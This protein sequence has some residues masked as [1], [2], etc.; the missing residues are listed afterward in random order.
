MTRRFFSKSEKNELYAMADGHCQECGIELER[1]WHADHVLPYSEGGPTWVGNGAALCPTCNHKK[2][3]KIMTQFTPRPFQSEMANTVINRWLSGESVTVAQVAPGSGKTIA[4]QL[5]VNAMMEKAGRPIFVQWFAPRVNLCEQAAESWAYHQ[6]MLSPHGSTRLSEPNNATPL[7]DPADAG[8]VTT[9][10]ALTSQ[11]KIHLDWARSNSGQF[12]MV[13]DE[14]QILGDNEQGGTAA[15]EAVARI[16]EHALHVIVMTGTPYRSDNKPILGATYSEPDPDG[17]RVLLPQA[18]STYLDGVALGYLRPVEIRMTDYDVSYPDGTTVALE[19]YEEGM[20]AIVSKDAV[21]AHVA[22]SVADDV[23]RLKALDSRYCGLI[24]CDLQ[25]HADR[26]TALLEREYPQLRIVKAISNEGPIGKRV[27]SDFR[28]GVGDLLVTCEMAYVGYDHKPISA[29]GVLTSKRWTG[30][31]EQLVARGLRSTDF[32]RAGHMCR[33]TIPNDPK[34]R[35]F[36][37]KLRTDAEHGMAEAAGTGSGGTGPNDPQ[38]PPALALLWTG[39]KFMGMTADQ[40]IADADRATLISAVADQEG[41]GY[42]P[43]TKLSALID[44]VSQGVSALPV[45]TAAQE[46]DRLEREI[47]EWAKDYAKSRTRDSFSNETWAQAHRE[48]YNEIHRR[49]GRRWFTGKGRRR[50][51]ADLQACHSVAFTI[52]RDAA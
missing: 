50:T 14:A 52:A 35:A 40:D 18:R 23:M 2:G 29:V 38:M 41:I 11:P 44:R 6:P 51:I 36:A 21:M 17:R 48:F 39:M 42:V 5:A 26:V 24:A 45:E 20:R 34:A 12:V 16:M 10:S 43:I 27:L 19:D 3:N 28:K 1:G 22:R 9:Y 7:R 30:Y 46:T 13:V 25:Q 8:Y 31:L 4:A 15:A 32:D 33:I 47:N 37:D 49:S